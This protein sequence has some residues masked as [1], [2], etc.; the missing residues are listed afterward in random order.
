MALLQLSFRL[1][2]PTRASISSSP[3]KSAAV[4]EDTGAPGRVTGNG[5]IQTRELKDRVVENMLHHVKKHSRNTISSVKNGNVN[6][7]APKCTRHGFN[8]L[9]CTAS[10]LLVIRWLYVLLNVF[11]VT[12]LACRLPIIGRLCLPQ[13]GRL[14]AGYGNAKAREIAQAW[15]YRI[16]IVPIQT[17]SS[18]IQD[19][20]VIAEAA[21]LS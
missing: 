14:P 21:A 9:D 20:L 19:R 6:R 7:P 18:I 5:W 10:S 17:S 12:N 11:F 15:E 13:M 2:G 4:S 3:N 1:C 8:E 16:A